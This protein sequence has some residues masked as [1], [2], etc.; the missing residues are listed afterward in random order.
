MNSRTLASAF[1][2]SLAEPVLDRL[3]VVVG[4]GL[5]VLDVLRIPLEKPT[6]SG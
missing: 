2:A 4:L 6:F 3:D 5:D 1:F